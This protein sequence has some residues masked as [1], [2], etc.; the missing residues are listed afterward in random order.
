MCIQPKA[1]VIILDINESYNQIRNSIF[2]HS[3][4]KSTILHSKW[5]LLK[6]CCFFLISL[7]SITNL[8]HDF[9]SPFLDIEITIVRNI[10][11][12][13]VYPLTSVPSTAL[14]VKSIYEV[15]NSWYGQTFDSVCI[16]PSLEQMIRL[17][18]FDH[19]IEDRFLFQCIAASKLLKY[20]SNSSIVKLNIFLKS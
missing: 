11:N 20:V 14:T 6:S 8:A 17:N 1:Q 10:P 12:L 4:E 18:Q 3:M 16:Y 7:R 5:T 2:L 13:Q 9:K 15:S 19:F